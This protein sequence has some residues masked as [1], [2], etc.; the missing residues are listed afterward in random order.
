MTN[1]VGKS[2]REARRRH[3]RPLVIYHS[4]PRTGPE[5]PP[6]KLGRKKLRRLQGKDWGDVPNP[7][8]ITRLDFLYPSHGV[9][10]G[11]TGDQ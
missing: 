10:N 1:R 8:R 7:V 11:R 5:L 2:E 9:R 3:K 4:W 6:V